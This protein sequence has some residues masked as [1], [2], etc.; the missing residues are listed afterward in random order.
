MTDTPSTKVDDMAAESPDPAEAAARLNAF[1]ARIAAGAF[2][3]GRFHRAVQTE[4]FPLL[5]AG[6][7]SPAAFNRLVHLWATRN[8]PFDWPSR[9]YARPDSA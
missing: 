7:L 4:L 6:L 3:D 8:Y 9:S 2:D 1:E 5:G